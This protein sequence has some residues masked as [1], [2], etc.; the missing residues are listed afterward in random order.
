MKKFLKPIVIRSLLFL[1]TFA[2]TMAVTDNLLNRGH[3]NLTMEMQEPTLPVITMLCGDVEYNQLHG[4][5]VPMDTASQRDT[6]TVLGEGRSTDLVVDT[7][8]REVSG[9]QAEVR[10]MDGSRLI[11]NIDLNGYEETEGRIPL[12]VSLKDLIEK[13][14]EYMLVI[15]LEMDGWQE[16]R[17][18]ARVVWD[19]ESHLKED[20]DYVLDFHDKLYEREAA[21]ELVKYLETNSRL[22]DNRSFHKVNIHSSFRQITWGDMKVSQLGDP[23]WT[24]REINGQIASFLADYY[25]SVKGEND[26]T[27]YRV[28]EYFR[29]RYTAQRMYLLDY[30]RTMTQV[31]DETNLYAGDKLLLGIA[32]ENV[33]MMENESGT[34]VAFTQADRLFSFDVAG[35]KLALL[36]SFYDEKNRDARSLYDRHSIKILGVGDEGSVDFAVYG[37]MNRGTREGENGIQINHY[38]AGTN[39]VEEIA[40]IPWDQAYSS[41]EREMKDLLYLNSDR[42]LYLSL[43]NAA[44]RVDLEKGT[45]EKVFDELYDGCMQVSADHRILVWQEQG[46]REYSPDIQVRDLEQDTQVTLHG[47]PG[48]ALKI[49]GFMDKDIIYGVADVRQISRLNSGQMFFPMYKLCICK[50]DGTISKEYSQDGIYIM[51]CSVE[52]NQITL[53]RMSLQEDG[54]FAVCGQDHITRTAQVQ[55]SKNQ[56]VVVDIDV[57]KRYVQIQVTGEIDQQKTQLLT[58]K[59]VIHEGED[60]LVLETESP[61]PRY[62]VYGPYGVDE[63]C[64]SVG[65]AVDR[66]YEVAGTVTSEAGEKI[67]QKGSRAARNQIMAIKEPEQVETSESLACCLDTMLRFKGIS[68]DSAKLL[69]E[70]QYPLDILQNNLTDASAIDMTG[71]NLDAM[72]YYVNQD[73]PVLAVLY[74]GEA[75]LVTGFNESQAVIF[76]PSTGSLY[77]K[78]L[79]DAD[80][81]FEENG[82]CFFTYIP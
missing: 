6:V 43:N 24:L 23:V 9:I 3:D 44:Y 52:E 8:G 33:A 10:S 45:Y 64:V 34:V 13:E 49:L 54:T 72:L 59:N 28:Q 65:S 70:G 15:L 4:Y 12:T 1:A 77:K 79:S 78:A 71:C 21:R 66:A 20:L 39:T 60:S 67:W 26:D 53:E 17:Y 55:G 80:Q 51:D 38:D 48:E 46:Q 61:V 32:D 50:P 62:F 29:V 42:I 41:L 47:Q 14:E 56:V 63:I 68:A 57:Y 16:V 35:Q 81:W 74:S 73:I 31:P 58:P 5:T 30:E 2:A 19:E 69:R 7:Y 27:Y 18:Y 22:E 82:N 75:V 76:Q 37:Y 11:E 25:V 36:F 40:Y